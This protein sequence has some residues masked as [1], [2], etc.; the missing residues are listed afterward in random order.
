MTTLAAPTMDLGVREIA[1]A[2][3]KFAGKTLADLLLL[4]YQ[5]RW[6]RDESKL[7]IIEKSRRVGIDYAEA[8]GVTES[9]LAGRRCDDYWYSSADETAAREFMDYIE[10][11]AESFES[12]AVEFDDGAEVFGKDD[13]TV[14]RAI[15]PKV[16]APNGK[17]VR[18]KVWAL[19]SNPSTFRSKGGDVGLSEFAFH[20]QPRAMWKAATPVATWGG[21]IRTISSHNGA[22]SEFNRYVQMAQRHAAGQPHHDDMPLSY[23][24]VTLDDAIGDGLVELINAVKGTDYTRESFRAE[25]RASCATEEDF[26]EEYLCIPNEQEG[27]FL[28]YEL[29]RP[30]VKAD[31]PTP[32]TDVSE[33][34]ASISERVKAIQPS[35][36]FAGCD[37]GRRDNRFVIWVIGKVGGAHRLMGVL[38]WRNKSFPEMRFA[39]EALMG[40]SFGS[41]RVRRLCMDATGLGMQLGEELARKYGGRVEDIQ[42]NQGV[43]DEIFT[44]LRRHTEERTTEY[45]DCPDTLADHTSVRK[46]VTAAGKVRFAAD[47]SEV[48]HA[49]R[50]T[51]HALALHAA[52]TAP[53]SR[54]VGNR[55]KPGGL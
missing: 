38:V 21:R 36:L 41:A 30:C 44:L 47:E 45:P 9:R 29:M 49:D 50:A 13:I 22:T 35:A 54:V 39:C 34:L 32:T 4:P 40:A 43:K 5:V 12:A 46:T 11:F 28:P 6:I 1:D 55:R 18:P 26:N 37:V 8:Y 42:F 19:T 15:F 3:R 7:A 31:A 27:S 20:K 10:L 25:C 23:H 53:R 14:F 24:R 51:A 48:G 2:L 16:K 17:M 52:D 33:F